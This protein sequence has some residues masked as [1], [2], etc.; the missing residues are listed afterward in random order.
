MKST[1]HVPLLPARFSRR[2]EYTYLMFQSSRAAGVY[3][4][5]RSAPR[6]GYCI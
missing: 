5:A 2:P 4:P 6:S 3:S 1:R